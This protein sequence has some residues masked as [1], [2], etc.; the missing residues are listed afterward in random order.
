VAQLTLIETSEWISGAEYARTLDAGI[1]E[2]NVEYGRMSDSSTTSEQSIGEKR[3]TMALQIGPFFL[4]FLSISLVSSAF[5]KLGS[6]SEREIC[7]LV[8]AVSGY[9][10]IYLNLQRARA[11]V[12]EKRVAELEK[13][14]AGINLRQSQRESLNSRD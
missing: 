7:T 14:V 9:I 4:L 11:A 12:F 5:F 6:E 3:L 10:G 13:Q 2:C 1:T 8:G